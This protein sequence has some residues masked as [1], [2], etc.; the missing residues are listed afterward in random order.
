[1]RREPI[2]VLSERI[3]IEGVAYSEGNSV[4]ISFGNRMARRNEQTWTIGN[5][6]RVLLRV[7]AVDPVKKPRDV[8]TLPVR[9]WCRS[10]QESYD[11]AQNSTTEGSPGQRRASPHNTIND[12]DLKKGHYHVKR[13]PRRTGTAI[14]GATTA[15]PPPP[16]SPRSTCGAPSWPGSSTTLGCSLPSPRFDWSLRVG[17]AVEKKRGLMNRRWNGS[18]QKV[19]WLG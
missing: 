13:L 18:D 11:E 6:Q 9:V 17:I 2:S 14:L 16:P 1:L 19:G 12:S 4:A 5:T 15:P 8:T 3:R 10:E 7:S